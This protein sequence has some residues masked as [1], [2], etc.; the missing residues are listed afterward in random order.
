[1]TRRLHVTP[2]P[3]VAEQASHLPH[4]CHF[5]STQSFALHS[6]FLHRAVSRILLTGQGS[7]PGPI[8][9][10]NKFR[11]LCVW[12]TPQDFVQSVQSCQSFHS[13][14]WRGHSGRSVAALVSAVLSVHPKPSTFLNV[15]TARWRDSWPDK[16][17]L[18]CFF[19]SPHWP[20]TQSS[21]GHDT[22]LLQ[23]SVSLRGLATHAF[24]KFFCPVSLR[25]LVVVPWQPELHLVQALQSLSVQSVAGKAHPLISYPEPLHGLPLCVAALKERVR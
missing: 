1:M 12:P 3:Q 13:Q 24:P 9:A 22:N 4:A 6:A 2:D 23:S 21:L 7:P 14:S 20:K 19:H 8:V 10:C 15:L 5:P 18:T 16:P 25:D 17:Q 11:V